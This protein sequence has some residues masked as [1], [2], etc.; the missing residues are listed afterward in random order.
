VTVDVRPAAEVCIRWPAGHAHTDALERTGEHELFDNAGRNVVRAQIVARRRKLDFLGTQHRDDFVLAPAFELLDAA[1]VHGCRA[2]T[3][4]LLRL[5]RE[6]QIRGSKERRDEAGR[7]TVVQL[8][9]LAALQQTTEVHH[10]DPV[11]EGER[12]LLIVRDEHGGDLQLALDLADRTTQLLAD[13]RVE[14]A[15]WFVEQQHR[16]LVRQRTRH[17]DALLLSTGKL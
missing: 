10:P 3:D 14:R 13:L 7:G 8:I 2:E 15:E 11:S 5:F 6:Q 17:C 4:A 12:F 16:G 9:G 1:R